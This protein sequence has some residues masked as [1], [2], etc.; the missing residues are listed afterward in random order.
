MIDIDV[1]ISCSVDE[2]SRLETTD[3]R[4]HHCQKSVGSNIERNSQE[5]IGAALVQLA[6]EFS[7][8]DIELEEGVARRE[9]HLFHFGHIPCRDDHSAGI[10]IV[11]YLIDYIRELVYGAA[12]RSRPAA[13][14]VSVY[15]SEVAVLVSP[16]VPDS[17][18]VILE[19]FDIGI[20]GD[21]PEKFV[22]YRFQMDFLSREKRKAFTEV[23]SHLV[24]EY[25]LGTG[26]GAI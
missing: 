20:S 23:K 21:E 4:D 10:R 25:A 14:L 7:V 3:L 6:G 11:L 9:S 18:T 1:S 24:A 22:D 12:V 17:H 5:D 26:S 15:R 19:V 2:F 8:S 13:P 16:F